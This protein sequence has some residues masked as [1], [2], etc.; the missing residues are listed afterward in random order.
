MRYGVM[1]AQ[2]ILALL[3]QVQLLVSQ[4]TTIKQNKYEFKR[5]R[6]SHKRSTTQSLKTS[7]LEKAQ[8]D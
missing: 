6:N 1:A 5:V 4:L 3:V 2:Q 7:G 8:V